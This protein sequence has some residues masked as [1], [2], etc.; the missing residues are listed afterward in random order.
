MDAAKLLTSFSLLLL[1]VG[2]VN[3]DQPFTG[4]IITAASCSEV[5]C[6][7]GYAAEYIVTLDNPYA[8]TYTITE[9][10]IQSVSART[11]N[12]TRFRNQNITF[13]PHSQ[14][15]LNIDASLPEPINNSFLFQA[16]ILYNYIDTSSFPVY[17]AERCG[18]ITVKTIYPR[19]IYFG[20]E[21]CCT[22]GACESTEQCL[23]NYTCSS[24]TCGSNEYIEN[25]MCVPYECTVNEDCNET[26]TCMAYGCRPINCDGTIVNRECHG[27]ITGAVFSFFDLI[28]ENLAI[29]GLVIF[30]IVFV[31]ALI[32]FVRLE[33]N[34]KKPGEKKGKKGKKGKKKGKKKEED[35]SEEDKFVPLIELPEE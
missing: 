23:S 8:W 17:N 12:D 9:Y 31:I 18:D 24:L 4:N 10:W 15:T 30:I 33:G 21:I 28:I 29:V 35:E 13:S 20:T 2:V 26:S 34:G 25:H 3:A 19:D 22:D 6:I 5:C 27:T 11:V 32:W 7:E 16:C 14:L 1:M